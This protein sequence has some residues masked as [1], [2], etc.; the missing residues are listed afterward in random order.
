M[1]SQDITAV[2]EWAKDVVW[3][4]IF[5]ERFNKGYPDINPS[6]KDIEGA[7]PHDIES[8]WQ[9]HPWTSEWYK[10]QPYEQANNQDIW[11]NLQ[12]RRYGGDLKGVLDKLD[13]LQ[14]LGIGAIYLNP[15]FY[16]PSSHKY[17][18]AS[19]HHVDPFFGPDPEHDLR[20]MDGE[21]PG[22]PDNWVWTEADKLLLEL[23]A[24]AHRRG[25]RIIL[26]GVFNHVGLNFWAYKDLEKNQRQSNYRKWFKVN[27]YA[28]PDS[29][30]SLNVKTWEGFNE[31]PELRQDENGL[32]EGPQKYIF[33]ITRRWMD[34]HQDGSLRQGIDGWR[35][36]VAA[37]IAHP[38]W[39]EWRRHVRSINPD[40]Y[41]TGEIFGKPEQ[42]AEY[43]KGDEFDA[44]MNYDF[45]F[46][47]SEYFV[48]E[49]YQIGADE[50]DRRLAD[51]R[52]AQREP[53]NY[54]LQ[55]LVGSHDTDRLGSKIVNRDYFNY[56]N[57]SRY[58]DLAKAVNPNYNTRKP[59][60]HEIQKQFLIALFQMTYIG[61]PM[62]Y[63]GD[64]AGMWGAND[65]CCRKPM[66]W[67]EKEYEPETL[68]S[69]GTPLPQPDTV[70]F[71]RELYNH[72]QQL[73]R[74][75]NN[76]IAL[77]RGS[78]FTLLADSNKQIHAFKRTHSEEEVVV[79][80]NN[81]NQEQ[82]VEL[83]ALK[84]SQ[85]QYVDALNGNMYNVN[86]GYLN[87]K[88]APFQGAVLINKA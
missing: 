70:E 55:N 10:L 35:L 84:L 12:R 59:T 68:K 38:F 76:H 80:T 4:Q 7:Y 20:L 78:Y 33:D 3:Y 61:A 77:R 42:L 21:E 88:L 63:Y 65:P 60:D 41:I 74:L 73:I 30:K 71:N 54:V 19:H 87:L 51:M 9:L 49:Q 28:D 53:V 24:E 85:N 23:I 14:K 50:F 79:V 39:K 43:M 72:Y 34:P 22:N 18:T 8:P 81:R 52:N 1:N 46:D 40:A 32:V 17:D 6:L 16:A 67:P 45:M 11:Y 62:L 27:R 69:D 75:R 25:M 26:D 37:C 48:D 47:I 58:H 2:P 57:W 31:L 56:R 13:Y 83:P 64:E 66:V 29:G 36:D 15:V 82:N 44:V 86:S 5:P